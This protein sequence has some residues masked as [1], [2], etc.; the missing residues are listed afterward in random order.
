M[1]AIARPVRRSAATPKAWTIR[2][3]KDGTFSVLRGGRQLQTGLSDRDA[4]A[5]VNRRFAVNE[6]VLSEDWQGYRSEITRRM[7][8]A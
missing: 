8:P 7:K 6:R 2:E 1:P 5:Y 4:L 3:D